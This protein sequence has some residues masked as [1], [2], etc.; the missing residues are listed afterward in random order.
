MPKLAAHKKPKEARARVGRPAKHPP[1]AR[2]RTLRMT[3]AEYVAVVLLIEQ[4]RG[5]RT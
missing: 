3:E 2:P 4:L 5:G 1:G